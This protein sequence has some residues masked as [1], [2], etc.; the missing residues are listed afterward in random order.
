MLEGAFFRTGRSYH[1]IERKQLQR[2]FAGQRYTRASRLRRPGLT[3]EHRAWKFNRQ[4]WALT[5]LIQPLLILRCSA[6]DG[7]FVGA[8]CVGVDNECPVNTVREQPTHIGR[9]RHACDAFRAQ[10]R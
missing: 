3:S 9:T 2:F 8:L 5:F 10:L 7:C 6:N 4:T 1:A